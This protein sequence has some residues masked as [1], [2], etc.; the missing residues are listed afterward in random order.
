MLDSILSSP[1][2]LV[3]IIIVGIIGISAQIWLIR[4]HR[5]LKRENEEM[6]K[7]L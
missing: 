6:K 2:F 7:N 1:L 4:D 5:R 3:V